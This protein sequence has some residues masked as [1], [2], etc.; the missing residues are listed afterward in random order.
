MENNQDLMV[1]MEKFPHIGSVL[2]KM[3]GA[4]E[5]TDYIDRLLY[6]TRDGKR[7]GFPRDVMAAL[8]SIYALH[9]KNGA[10]GT[11]PL[12]THSPP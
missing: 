1:V 12:A 6:D 8:M 10:D 7:Q 11:D 5:V 3:W 4:P 2:R 9:V